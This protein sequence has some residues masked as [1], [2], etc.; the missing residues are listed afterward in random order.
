MRVIPMVIGLLTLIDF[1]SIEPIQ[2]K[3]ITVT[4]KDGTQIDKTEAEAATYPT[5]VVSI[6]SYFRQRF[7]SGGSSISFA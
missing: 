6:S 3:D 1:F 5:I 7:F 2:Y 4:H